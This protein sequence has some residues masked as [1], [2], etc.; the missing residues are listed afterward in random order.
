M[1]VQRMLEDEL[2]SHPYRTLAI[3]AGIGCALATRL[4][5]SVLMPLMARAGM[6]MAS[7]AIAPLLEERLGRRPA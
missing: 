7:R 3:A 4:G 5:R 6:S 2:R 1:S